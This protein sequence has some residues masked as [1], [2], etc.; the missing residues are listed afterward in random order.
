MDDNYLDLPGG[1]YRAVTMRAFDPTT[2]QWSIWWL[3]GRNP[4]SL[5][6]PMRG[7]FENGVGCFLADD[8]L[9][10]RNIKVRF[11]W[12]PSKDGSPR[13]EQAFSEDNGQTW[14]TN[15]IMTFQPA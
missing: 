5:G 14:E 2:R 3:D 12:Y 7:S 11:L 10:G 6:D 4:G 1:A 8:V 9:Q 13:W 15:W